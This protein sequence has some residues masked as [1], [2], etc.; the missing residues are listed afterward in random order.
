MDPKTGQVLTKGV[1]YGIMFGV[2]LLFVGVAIEGLVMRLGVI[3]YPAGTIPAS[4]FTFGLT[5]SVWIALVKAFTEPDTAGQALTIGAIG[6]IVLGVVLLFV[7][8]PLES[9][10]TLL[11]YITYPTGTVPAAM[12]TFGLA[13]NVAVAFSQ[14]LTA[15][16]RKST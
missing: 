9:L 8:V 12:F 2:V 7:G 3:T 5:G 4:L 6:G 15:E 10:M 1:I 16:S 14:Y 11:G 13:G